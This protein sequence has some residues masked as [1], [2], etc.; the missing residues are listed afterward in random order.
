MITGG[1]SCDGC[2]DTVCNRIIIW[3]ILNNGCPKCAVEDK[4]TCKNIQKSFYHKY[5]SLVPFIKGTTQKEKEQIAKST[6][7]SS[8]AKTITLICP[9]CQKERIIQLF[10]LQGATN[11][12]CKH[13]KRLFIE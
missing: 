4:A 5:K 3:I 8:S 6:Y 1:I 7:A 12:R 13:C 11:I 9:H 2:P 10:N